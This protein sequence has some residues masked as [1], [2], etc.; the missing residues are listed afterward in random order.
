M[1]APMRVASGYSI[2]RG[3]LCPPLP[4]NRC[5]GFP[6]ARGEPIS[7]PEP[8]P[9]GAQEPRMAGERDTPPLAPQKTAQRHSIYTVGQA[10]HYLSLHTW[11]GKYPRC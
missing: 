4:N 3:S 1:I 5:M 10:F 9:R 11:S 6:E 7:R 2:I 8:I